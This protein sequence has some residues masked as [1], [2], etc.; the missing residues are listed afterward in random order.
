MLSLAHWP[1]ETV[2][3]TLLSAHE[4]DVRSCV[5]RGQIMPDQIP[6][7][8]PPNGAL[9]VLENSNEGCSGQSQ[10]L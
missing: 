2:G 3:G 10:L 4:Q 1:E 5:Y 6:Y 9:L 8:S 7:G